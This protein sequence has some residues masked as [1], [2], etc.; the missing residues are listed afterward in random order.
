M[1]YEGS[2]YWTD[3]GTLEAYRAAQH[4]VLS[5]K[6]RV[7]IP[8]ERRGES[9]WLDRI[10]QIHPTAVIEGQVVLRQDAVVG[11]RASPGGVTVGS[12][13]RI[14]SG[15]TVKR[16]ILLPRACVGAEAYLDGCIVGHGYDVPPGEQVRGEVLVRGGL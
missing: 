1:G 16:S 14:R 9:L 11:R 6:V 4:D 13:C 8:G 5:G 7:R 12:G 15:A 10:A 2:F 3:V